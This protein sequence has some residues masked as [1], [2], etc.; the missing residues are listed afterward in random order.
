MDKTPDSEPSEDFTDSPEK[1]KTPFSAPNFAL[2]SVLL[3]ACFLLGNEL[4]L[5]LGLILPGNILGLFIL[6]ALLALGIVPMR[7]VEAPAL[8]L[9]WLLPLLFMPIFTY[10]LRDGHFWLTR[11]PALFVAI[12]AATILLWT[13]VGHVA[14][15]LLR[16][17]NRGPQ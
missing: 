9:L 4:K 10:A 8:W 2:G 11:G 12:F 15:A 1:I 5:R 14:Q 6:L 17:G 3:V 16:R 13:I 7:W